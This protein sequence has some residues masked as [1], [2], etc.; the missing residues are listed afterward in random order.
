MKKALLTFLV[1]F[2]VLAMVVAAIALAYVFWGDGISDFLQNIGSAAGR[3]T[4]DDADRYRAGADSLSGVT[5]LDVEWVDGGITIERYDG[6]SVEFSETSDKHISEGMQLHYMLDGGTLYIK[7][8]KSGEKINNLMLDKQLVIKIPASIAADF[9]SVNIDCVSSD[10]TVSDIDAESIAV[11]GVSGKVKISGC[12]CRVFSA[13]CVSGALTAAALKADDA[14]FMSVSGKIDA[15]GEFG[16]VDAESVSGSVTITNGTCCDTK[17][18]TVS[19]DATL[20]MNGDA[21]FT[22]SYDETSGDLTCDFPT[23]LKNG[24]YICNGGGADIEIETVSGDAYIR[25]K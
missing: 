25:I 13:E 6:G 23:S 12:A 18:S 7:Y 24:K 15:E 11:N 8:C 1:I 3:F 17:I 5:S 2:I 14:T 20:I 22:L 4:Y 10:T 21:A 16:E 9:G 19:G